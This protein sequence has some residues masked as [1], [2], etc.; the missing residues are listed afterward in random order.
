MNG[1]QVGKKTSAGNS[2][3]VLIEDAIIKNTIFINS[4]SFVKLY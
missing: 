3:I 4:P 2:K 1:D